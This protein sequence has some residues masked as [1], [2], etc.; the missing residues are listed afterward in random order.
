M[1]TNCDADILLESAKFVTWYFPLDDIILEKFQTAEDGVIS[2]REFFKKF[3]EIINGNENSSSSTGMNIEFAKILADIFL[4]LEKRL[5]EKQKKFYAETFEEYYDASVIEAAFR[6][7]KQPIPFDLYML[8]RR[9]NV[10][11]FPL[12]FFAQFDCNVDMT[13]AYDDQTFWDMQISVVD[14]L[15]ALNDAYSFAKDIAKRETMNLVFILKEN[16]NIHFEDCIEILMELYNEA[17]DNFDKYAQILIERYSNRCDVKSYISSVKN[18]FTA[19]VLYHKFS[20]RYMRHFQDE[21]SREES[22]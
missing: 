6:T 10:G 9:T 22:K 2:R 18:I 16:S 20:H 15:I 5:S 17:Q 11:V 12:L 1:Y 7:R 3:H 4:K 8:I 13:F 14:A 21:K 19:N